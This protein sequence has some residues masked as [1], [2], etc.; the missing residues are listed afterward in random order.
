M[1]L[2]KTSDD[3]KFRCPH[4]LIIIPNGMLRS[5]EIK[6]PGCRNYVAV[7]IKYL[8]E[9][10]P[11]P[12]PSVC[13]RAHALTSGARKDVYGHPS[14][15]FGNIAKHW[16]TYLGV[17]ITAEQVAICQILLKVERLRHAP[18]HLDSIVDICGYGNCM[19]MILERDKEQQK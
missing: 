11:T 18:G 4:C 15:N 12:A 2:S 19:G 7:P 16:S 1:G 6:C 5:V 14:E 3:P 17:A 9:D 10:P 13:Q 8:S